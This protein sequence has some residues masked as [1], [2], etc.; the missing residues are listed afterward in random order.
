[1][2]LDPKKK[3]M[4][5]DFK[6]KLIQPIIYNLTLILVF[7]ILT[8]AIFGQWFDKNSF[9]PY[10]REHRMKK[11]KIEYS[12]QNEK[13]EKHTIHPLL[14]PSKSTKL[15]LGSRVIILGT[16]NVEQRVPQYVGVEAEIVAVPGES[17]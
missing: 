15:V 12:D 10:M 11:Q 16:D 5:S 3:Y 2:I 7:L 14:S 1:M 13:V 6:T 8:E 17:N 9:G 4:S